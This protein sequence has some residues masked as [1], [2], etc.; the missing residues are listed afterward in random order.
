MT[1][2]AKR[3]F[4]YNK[5]DLA[6]NSFGHNSRRNPNPELATI[7]CMQHFSISVYY[8]EKRENK[9]SRNKLSHCGNLLGFLRLFESL[10]EIRKKSHLCQVQDGNICP[11][12]NAMH[13]SGRKSCFIFIFLQFTQSTMNNWYTLMN[14]LA[15]ICSGKVWRNK[16][17]RMISKNKKQSEI[18]LA[19]SFTDYLEDNNSR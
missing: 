2:G 14:Y 10:V 6:H 1:A 17:S 3:T 15:P 4:Y 7:F 13:E 16:I 11:C 12:V 9:P 8:L 18:F 5:A 19:N